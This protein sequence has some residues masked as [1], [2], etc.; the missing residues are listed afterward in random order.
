MARK[1][2][3]PLTRR[4]KTLSWLLRHDATYTF[5]E[6]GLR[7]IEDLITAHGFTMQELEEIVSGDKK[8]RFAFSE[9]KLW[10]R[11]RYGHSIPIEMTGAA[12]IVPDILYHGTA[13]KSV[14]SIMENGLDRMSRMYVHLTTDRDT[15][16]LTGERHG[17]PIVLEVD[18]RGMKAEGFIFF[19]AGEGIWLTKEVPAKFISQYIDEFPLDETYSKISSEA[20]SFMDS[21]IPVEVQDINEAERCLKM[22]CA[23]REKDIAQP[24]IML[25]W[26]DVWRPFELG[27]CTGIRML[28]PVKADTLEGLMD[29]IKAYC[30]EYINPEKDTF[31][32]RYFLPAESDALVFNR[33]M[34]LHRAICPKPIVRATLLGCSLFS[35]D[36]LPYMAVMVVYKRI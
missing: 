30:N 20:D 5:K 14:T 36:E 17:N 18:A 16:I 26:N 4:S 29:K 28:P 11:A 25:D 8:V 33:M 2:E 22:A 15:A 34:E 10:I 35:N 7:S 1:T 3:S 13:E 21:L 12:D 24:F 6:N 19:D 23:Y 31:M 27:E 9:D 32:V